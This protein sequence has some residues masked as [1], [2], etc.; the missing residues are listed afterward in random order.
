MLG[1]NCRCDEPVFPDCFG[2]PVLEIVI[3]TTWQMDF[4]AALEYDGDMTGSCTQTTT[5]TTPAFYPYETIRTDTHSAEIELPDLTALGVPSLLELDQNDLVDATGPWVQ[6]IWASNEFALYETGHILGATN[7]YVGCPSVGYAPTSFLGDEYTGTDAW[8]YASHGTLIPPAWS[9]NRQRTTLSTTNYHCGTVEY[10]G[11][12]PWTTWSCGFQVFGV[13]AIL[14][15]VE[16]GASFIFT[17]RVFWW[18]RM[19]RRRIITEQTRNTLT[20]ALGP[21]RYVNGI[22]DRWQQTFTGIP[23][24][25]MTMF[26]SALTALDLSAGLLLRYTKTVD[27]D[28][29]FLGNPVTLTL[30]EEYMGSGATQTKVAAIGILNVPSTI[31]ITA[32]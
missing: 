26:P 32:V 1:Q 17:V 10:P 31:T 12:V 20:G 23:S 8:E 30:V 6:C 5:T 18:P 21:V 9:A 7:G 2:C 22:Y 14:T 4:A 11:C 24:N 19:H 15:V 29:D 16:S 3:P 13:Y 27:C 28:T 25:C